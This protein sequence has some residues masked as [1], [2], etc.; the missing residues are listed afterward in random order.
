MHQLN[1]F[2]FDHF[3][4]LQLHKNK[5]KTK[6][7]NCRKV[8]MRQLNDSKFIAVAIYNVAVPSVIVAPLVLFISSDRPGISFIL[9]ASCII[10]GTTV[11]NCLI[12]IPKV[13]RFTSLPDGS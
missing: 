7:W 1:D 5:L 13:R 4:F 3:E 8:T 12:F 10:F 9:T 2:N 6:S 11:T